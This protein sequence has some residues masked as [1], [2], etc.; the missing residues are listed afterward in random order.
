METPETDQRP[1]TGQEVPGWVRVIFGFPLAAFGGFVSMFA[2]IFL[3][4]YLASRVGGGPR[5]PG[6]L[7]GC[8]FWLFFGGAPLALG[9]WLLRNSS[10]ALVSGK[11]CLGGLVLFAVLGLDSLCGPKNWH[12]VF[13]REKSVQGDAANLKG[14]FVTPHLAAEIQ[15][16]TNLLWCGTFQL[17]WNE[18]C[19][20][21]GGDLRL[22]SLQPDSLIQSPMA[23]A[24]NRHSFTK[25]CIDDASYVVMSGLVKD[26]IHAKIGSAVQTK[27]EFNPRLVPDKHL[28]PR[29]QDLVVY[30]CLAK[31][32]FF[33]VPF[34]RLDDSFSFAGKQVRAFGLGKTK[35][36]HE[37]MCPHVL[38]LDYQNADDFVVELKT[39]SA[40]D[41]LILAKLQPKGT[42]AEVAA[43]V[44]GRAETRPGQPPRTWKPITR[45]WTK[46]PARC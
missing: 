37:A 4:L 19:T 25:D 1:S 10:K 14:T 11:V 36:S 32:L 3:L 44:R 28:T 30:A 42:L 22:V 15:P 21:A 7:V 46:S 5:A 45:G 31:K 29:P 17:A 43:R 16:G 20:H 6:F 8:L 18:S 33:P 40:G 27:L 13:R 9:T 38:I 34:E 26:H 35:A 39:T 24:L 12:G 2:V 23:A 41:R